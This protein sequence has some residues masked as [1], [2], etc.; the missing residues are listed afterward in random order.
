MAIGPDDRVLVT[1]AAA[2]F[3]LA[4]TRLLSQRR[5]RVL[6]TDVA[7]ETP[8]G[9]DDLPGVTYRRLDVRSQDDWDAARDFVLREWKGLDVLFNNA[10]VGSGGD[11]DDEAIDAWQHV[12][13]INLLGVV[14]GCKTF[15]PVFKDQRAGR[16]V[17][18][19]SAAGLVHP[20]GMASYCSAKAGVVALSECMLFE[21][22]SFGITVSAICPSFFQSDIAASMP[23]GEAKR[24]AAALMKASGRTAEQVARVALQ[25]VDAGHHLVLPDRGAR[26]AYAAKRFARPLYLRTMRAVAAKARGRRTRTPEAT[27]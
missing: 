9:L 12:I 3:G 8:A 17:N 4:L 5:C 21:L 2:G 19:A 26:T 10:G 7:A 24:A 11:I 15:V 13:S 23:D 18:T 16:I 22:E 25:G 20:P 6:S 27:R 1:G 14:R